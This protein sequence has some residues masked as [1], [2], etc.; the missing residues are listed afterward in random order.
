MLRTDGY[1]KL[2]DFGLA[3]LT[4]GQHVNEGT[5]SASIRAVKT[6]AEVVMGTARY[7]SPEQA[8]RLD[9]DGRTD[10]WS[11]GVVLYE[12]V[13]GHAP[14]E[15]DTN[16]DVIVSI[17]EREPPPIT[18]DASEVAA[19]LQRIIT[20]ALHKNREERYPAVK[21]MLADL[22]SLKQDPGF[23]RSFKRF[24]AIAF[25]GASRSEQVALVAGK[26]FDGVG[27]WGGIGDWRVSLALCLP[28]YFW[29]T[30]TAEQGRSFHHLSRNGAPGYFFAGWQSDCFWLEWR[31][32]RR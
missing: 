29:P 30:V 6:D 16:S 10:I 13:G 17:L 24:S 21:A 25:E 1:V 3:K 32:G 11:L 22:K 28:P 31:Q 26:H 7:M 23:R 20:K 27:G 9:V 14:F 19:G 12:I 5:A 4:E 18:Q 15:G 8:R 2:L